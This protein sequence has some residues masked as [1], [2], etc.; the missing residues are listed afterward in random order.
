[1]K[2]NANHVIRNKLILLVIALLGFV[3]LGAFL[4]KNA[5]ASPS[6]TWMIIY[7]VDDFRQISATELTSFFRNLRIPIPPMIGLLEILSIRFL[8]SPAPVTVFAYRLSLI[9][10]YAL[11]IILASRTLLRLAFSTVVAMIF[12]YATVKIHPG[13]PQGYDIFFPLLFL[14]YLLLLE[15]TANYQGKGQWAL[16]LLAGFALSMTELSRPFVI[17]ALPF[18]ILVSYFKLSQTASVRLFIWFLAPILLFS[19]LWHWHLHHDLGQITFSNHAGYNLARCWEGDPVRSVELV[20]EIHDAPLVEGRWPNL[21][22]PEHT[23]N[24]R[25]I[26]VAIMSYWF[27]H[28]GTSLLYMIERVDDLLSAKT[29]IYSNEPKSEAFGLYRLLVKLTSAWL[30]INLGTFALYI[31]KNKFRVPY[32]KLLSVTDHILLV[33]TAYCILLLSIGER[34]E[35]A[36]FLISILPFLT[37]LPA[38]MAPKQTQ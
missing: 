9:G 33:F 26:Q 28:P 32:Q 16:S 4:V 35:E 10:A 21:N 37:V 27:H 12:L 36:R 38:F 18:L 8:G 15:G 3:A 6:I 7:D 24:S 17:Y 30:L 29:S 13:N 23:E 19:G 5:K 22:T 34:G 11:A 2:E 20:K 14:S 1:M 25:R 31:V